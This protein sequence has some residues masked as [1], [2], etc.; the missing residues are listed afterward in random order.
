M[1]IGQRISKLRKDYSFSQEYVAEKLGISRQAV[2]KWENDTTAPDTYNLIALA[3]LFN[4]SVEYIAVGKQSEQE[5]VLNLPQP[6][7]ISSQKVLGFIFLGTGLLSLILGLLFSVILIILSGVFIILGILCLLIRKHRPIVTSWVLWALIFMINVV[8]KVFLGRNFVSMYL[9]TFLHIYI[10]YRLYVLEIWFIINLVAT[11]K[12][13][14][15]HKKI[16]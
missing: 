8:I 11:I 6:K 3:E 10:P 5:E 15:K 16:K 9:A 1:T 14:V 2:S 7:S 12:L 4:V 13:I